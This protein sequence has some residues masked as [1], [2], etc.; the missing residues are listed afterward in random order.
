[1]QVLRITLTTLLV[2]CA[3]I[4]TAL[5]ARRELIVARTPDQPLAPDLILSDSLWQ[6]ISEYQT[7]SGPRS[8]PVKLVE[9]YDYEC[10]F[11]GDFQPVLDTIR[12]KYPDEVTVIYRHYPLSYHTGAYDAAIAAECA[13]KQGAFKALH[14]LLF[15]HQT[16]LSGSVNWG[17]LARKAGIPDAMRFRSCIAEKLPTPKIDADTMAAHLLGVEGIPTLV[18]L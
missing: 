1:M 11:C 12:A 10:P 17:S 7:A 15:A 3:V 14:N 6:V 4:V 16:Q 13:E 5:V 9:F 18:I 2:I 8:A